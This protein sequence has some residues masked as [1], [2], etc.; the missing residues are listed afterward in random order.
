[1]LS[2]HACADER[3]ALIRKARDAGMYPR[4]LAQAVESLIAGN[5]VRATARQTGV[6]KT[7]AGKLFRLL[8]EN[9]RT[10]G[11]GQ[12]VTHIG[13][14][15]ARLKQ[16]GHGP[17]LVSKGRTKTVLDRKEMAEQQ[18]QFLRRIEALTP[19]GLPPH[20]RAEFK[21]DL[22]IK[23]LL[24]EAFNV[25]DMIGN[26]FGNAGNFDPPHL[27]STDAPLAE[28][29]T[30]ADTLQSPERMWTDDDTFDFDTHCF[31]CGERG[32]IRQIHGHWQCQDCGCIVTTCCG[33]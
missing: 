3:S 31:G 12:P 5:G 11:C 29:F 27:L 8:Q 22:A 20:I 17:R 15:H 4:N 13:W 14:C 6:S 7:T 21:Q 23:L 19:L 1:M 2:R 18:S 26:A 32:H 9:I 10:C 16:A 25:R 28:D 24:G 33:D 30:I